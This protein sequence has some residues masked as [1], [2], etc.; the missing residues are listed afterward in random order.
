MYHLDLLGTH[1]KDDFLCDLFETY[2]VQVEYLYDRTHENL[3]DEYHTEVLD[4][5][6]QFVFDD[7]QVLRTLFLTPVDISTFNPFASDERVPTFA[8]KSDA[9]SHASANGEEFSEGSADFMG[10]QKEWIRFEANAYTIHYEY[11][12]GGLRKITLQSVAES[13]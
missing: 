10:E 13:A 11:V 1:L 12:D 6:L 3:P 9:L 8:S 4:L 2:D 7:H 5:G